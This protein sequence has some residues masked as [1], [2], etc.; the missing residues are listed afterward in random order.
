MKKTSKLI[1]RKADI[2]AKDSWFCGDWGT[3]VAFDG[4]HYHI[5]LF[6]GDDAAIFSR[7]E[8]RVRKEARPCS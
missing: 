1:G 7:N 4:E 6:D 8:F 3:I 2:V 5:A